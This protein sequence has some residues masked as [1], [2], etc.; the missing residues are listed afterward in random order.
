MAEETSRSRGGL[1]A[2]L[3]GALGGKGIERTDQVVG[4]EEDAHEA[5]V[6]KQP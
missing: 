4:G 6:S 3:D 5:A 1:A 2:R